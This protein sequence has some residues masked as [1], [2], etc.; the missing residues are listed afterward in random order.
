M[1]QFVAL[2]GVLRFL[3]LSS[4]L[5]LPC[6]FGVT[7]VPVHVTGL[8]IQVCVSGFLGLNMLVCFVSCFCSIFS[9]CSCVRVS[10]IV[11]SKGF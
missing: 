8:F 7:G 10:C 5:C 2:P 3:I 6:L 11:P 9:Y 1:L 4:L